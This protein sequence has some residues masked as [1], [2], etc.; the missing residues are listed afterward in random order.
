[1]AWEGFEQRRGVMPQLLCGDG[2]CRQKDGLTNSPLGEKGRGLLWEWGWPRSPPKAWPLG[3][4]SA[5]PR[6]FLCL[7]PPGQGWCA[8]TA[9][10][11]CL[12]HP[13]ESDP[14]LSPEP[15]TL[16]L[17][18]PL[19][20][21]RVG[22][23][24]GWRAG[25]AGRAVF[26]GIVWGKRIVR[27]SLEQAARAGCCW[28]LGD[29][30]CLPQSSASGGGGWAWAKAVGWAGDFPREVAGGSGSSHSAD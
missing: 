9:R 4:Q 3:P 8:C 23:P 26:L 14:L 27:A 22:W 25:R 15:L 28:P 5:S 12:G 16:R 20:R 2:P 11:H 17:L 1:M 18:G 10:R 6:S 29:A 21:G 24:P 13:C 19:W 30:S 7:S